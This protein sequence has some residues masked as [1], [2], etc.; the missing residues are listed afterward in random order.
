MCACSQKC[1]HVNMPVDLGGCECQWVVLS[2]C[3]FHG[4]GVAVIGNMVIGYG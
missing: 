1:C 4:C 3:G 2:G